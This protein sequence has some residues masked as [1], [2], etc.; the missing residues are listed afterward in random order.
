MHK[1]S[2][3]NDV[4]QILRFFL[5]LSSSSMLNCCFTEAF[6]QNVICDF[7]F[8]TYSKGLKPGRFKSRKRQKLFIFRTTFS[9][10]KPN[11]PSCPKSGLISMP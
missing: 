6:I 8:N 2:F 7:Y 11:G 1:G 4:T 9:V 5:P 10:Q 3:I